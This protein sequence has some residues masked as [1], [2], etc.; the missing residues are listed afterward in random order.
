M[1]IGI[2]PFL[3]P[4]KVKGYS[5]APKFEISQEHSAPCERERMP[6]MLKASNER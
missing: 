4:E 5:S 3:E 1:L 6:K 2:K